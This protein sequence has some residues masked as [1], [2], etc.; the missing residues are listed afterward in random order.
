M[1][2]KFFQKKRKVPKSPDRAP[3]HILV[4]GKI[5]ISVVIEARSPITFAGQT[6]RH[7]ALSRYSVHVGLEAW[8]LWTSDE[9]AIRLMV[10]RRGLGVSA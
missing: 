6:E 9:A 7:G 1:A 10:V 8:R 4:G 3:L 5:G 2:R